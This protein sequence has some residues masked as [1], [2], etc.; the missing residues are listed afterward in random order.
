MGF[1]LVG[2]ILVILAYIY[3]LFFGLFLF[4]RLICKIFTVFKDD[5][6]LFD[7][8]VIKFSVLRITLV[9]LIAPHQKLVGG[10]KVL[11][12]LSHLP[13]AIRGRSYLGLPR[14]LCNR[15]A[16]DHLKFRD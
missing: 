11:L 16:Q 3:S 2:L 7:L 9:R 15:A 12:L 1:K 14:S 13:I 5:S 8:C 6:I 10:C 4:L